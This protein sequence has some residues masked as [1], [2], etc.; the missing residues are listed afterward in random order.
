MIEAHQVIRKIQL[1]PVSRE[2][3]EEGQSCVVSIRT[4]QIP[5]LAYTINASL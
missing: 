2:K 3:G 1:M 5:W 4:K